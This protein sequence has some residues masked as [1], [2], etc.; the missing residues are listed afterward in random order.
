MKERERVGG[1]LAASC[2]ILSIA[3]SIVFAVAFATNG[4]TQLEGAGLGVACLALAGALIVWS[5]LLLPRERVADPHRALRSPERLR[6]DAVA[7]L[8]NGADELV[9]RRRWLARLG[10]AT[11]GFLGLA[12][13][14]PLRSLGPSPVGKVGRSNWRSGLR[15]VLEDGTL[16]RA[17]NVEP[18][19]VVTAFP[20][21]FT[22]RNNEQAMANDA[23]VLVHVDESTLELPPSRAG[24]TPQGFVAYSKVCTH[25][26]CP[27]ALYRQGPQQLFCPC[28]QS[29]FNVLDG[30]SVVFGP[31]ARPLPQLPLELGKG[32][33][34][35]AGGAFS[36]SIGPESWDA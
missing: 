24:W 17:E 5:R 21:G 22:G 20:E 4:S 34:L 15:L 18:G 3:G 36:G 6:D 28:H 14:F 13:L 10:Y 31:A 25:A 26:G 32:G 33:T 12:A 19:S 29:T 23:I 8:R 9:G 27:V 1:R 30:G 16:V 7:Q 2:L 35:E 11:L